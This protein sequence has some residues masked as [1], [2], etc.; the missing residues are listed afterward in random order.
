ML[1]VAHVCGTDTRFKTPCGAGY[2]HIKVTMVCRA[3]IMAKPRYPSTGLARRLVRDGDANFPCCVSLY[4]PSILSIFLL[5]SLMHPLT[6]EFMF[7]VRSKAL[8]NCEIIKLITYYCVLFS[9]M[10][11]IVLFYYRRQQRTLSGL[12]EKTSVPS[13]IACRSPCGSQSDIHHGLTNLSTRDCPGASRF[14][15]PP[16]AR[17][18]L[19]SHVGGCVVTIR[20]PRALIHS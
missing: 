12:I 16:V 4:V 14:R 19:D 17:L 11:E 3:R 9:A 2:L 1:L 6:K 15:G 13:S 10:M 8:P 5:S 7:P 18:P 20:S